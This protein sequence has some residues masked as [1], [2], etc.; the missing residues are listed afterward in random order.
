MIATPLTEVTRRDV[1]DGR[2]V[3]ESVHA[4]HLVVAGA[5]G[6][7][8]ARLGDPDATVF[9]RSAAKPFQAT[10]CL[11]VLGEQADAVSDAEVAVA[12]AS[13][14]AEP[15]HLAQVRRLLARSLT[16]AVELTCTPA[17][18]EADPGAAPAAL[19]N[20]CSGKHAMFALAGRVLGVAGPDLLN[21]GQEL[22]RRVLGVLGEALGPARAVGTDGCGAPAVAGPLATLAVAYGRLAVEARWARVREAGLAHPGLVGG[23]GRLESALLAAGVVAKVGAE[24]VYGVGWTAPDGTGRGLAVKAA[25]GSVRGAAEAVV[26]VVEALGVVPTGCWVSPPPLGGGRP[27]GVVRCAPPVMRLVATLRREGLTGTGSF[28]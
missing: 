15:R 18:G 25:D 7:V 3:V 11:E 27:A 21:P 2:E 19:S 6:Q 5:D 17:V 14:R 9:V 28:G 12:W 10:A 20:N 24:G 13:H 22:Q 8:L 23:Y 16:P 4:G 26:A 1:R